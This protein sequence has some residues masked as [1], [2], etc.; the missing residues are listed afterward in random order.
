MGNGGRFTPNTQWADIDLRQTP[1]VVGRI[2]EAPSAVQ[3]SIYTKHQWKHPPPDIHPYHPPLPFEW[4][5]ALRFLRE[6][7]VQTGLIITG[8]ALGVAVIVFMSALLAA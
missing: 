2:S 3:I 4:L 6:G 5:L 1:A 8:I 7:P